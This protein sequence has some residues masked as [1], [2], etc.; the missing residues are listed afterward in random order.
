MWPRD[1]LFGY[2]ALEIAVSHTCQLLQKCGKTLGFAERNNC[3]RIMDALLAA[4]VNTGN[5]DYLEPP[6][7]Q[8]AY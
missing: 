2:T 8:L 1:S 4:D 6:D 3:F 5:T 7:Y